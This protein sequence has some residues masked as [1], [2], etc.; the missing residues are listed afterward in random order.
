MEDLV[1]KVQRFLDRLEC[2]GCGVCIEA[3]GEIIGEVFGV[4]VVEE[5]GMY[6][7]TDEQYVMSKPLS[8][9]QM[10][11]GLGVLRTDDLEVRWAAD[12]IMWLDQWRA[13][14]DS[15]EGPGD[16]VREPGTG[17]TPD[18]EALEGD[19]AGEAGRD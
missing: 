16:T 11:A 14:Y 13:I 1:A 15:A 4:T 5:D 12:R 9:V 18:E 8:A 2:I 3:V 19:R 10:L 17:A 6:R 7:A